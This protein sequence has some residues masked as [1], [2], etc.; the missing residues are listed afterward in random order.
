MGCVL[1][2]HLG[3]AESLPSGHYYVDPSEPSETTKREIVVSCPDCGGR[4]AITETH[5]VKANGAVTPIYF[6]PT[7]TCGFAAFVTL[8]LYSWAVV[9]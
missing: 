9:A 4:E 3:P 8:E 2:R 1:K 7:V 6:C 5:N